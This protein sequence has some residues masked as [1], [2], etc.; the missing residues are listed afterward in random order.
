MN[1]K[2]L[3]QLKETLYKK[4]NKY[5]FEQLYPHLKQMFGVGDEYKQDLLLIFKLADAGYYLSEKGG[6]GNIQSGEFE[7]LIKKIPETYANKQELFGRLFFRLIDN[8]QV[9]NH[10]IN[11]KEFKR[12][13][14]F[15][16]E[17]KEYQ[18]EDTLN[19]SCDKLLNQLENTFVDELYKVIS[20]GKD[21]LKEDQFVEWY[22][23]L[24]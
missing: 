24:I 2:Q 8:Q 22:V 4:Q 13:I 9:T 1:Q 6:D 20:G 3:H 12:F 5:S 15:L 16:F 11:R 10:N 17:I 18:P 21:E 7:R 23:T 19:D 14:E